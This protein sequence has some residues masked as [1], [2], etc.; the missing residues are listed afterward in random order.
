MSALLQLWLPI[1]LSSVVVFVASSLI[2]MLTKWHAGDYRKLPDQEKA[3][4]AIG[5]LRIPPGD[6]CLPRPD[7]MK[8]MGTPE[9]LDKLRQGP[10]VIMTVQPNEVVNMGKMLAAWFLYIVAISFCSGLAAL[11]AVGDPPSHT[12]IFHFVGITAL[13]GYSGALAQMAIWYGR[14]WTTTIKSMIDGLI[15]ALLTAETFS[16]LW[17]R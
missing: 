15:Y 9:F 3:R 10:R 17:P 4:A 8:D 7:N 5:A 6:Y 13:M 12:R 16:L 14:S 1:L 2:H 11:H